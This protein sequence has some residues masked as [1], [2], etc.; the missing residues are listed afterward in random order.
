MPRKTSQ[1]YL[2]DAATLGLTLAAS[3]VLFTYLGYLLDQWLATSPA[4]LLTGSLI[5]LFGGM[6]HVVR[7]ATQAAGGQASRGQASR[8][9]ASRGEAKGG[10]AKGGDRPGS[11]AVPPGARDEDA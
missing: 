5:G 2:A 1:T 10:K 7:R 6:L 3:L 4:F 11:A 9:Q 8:G